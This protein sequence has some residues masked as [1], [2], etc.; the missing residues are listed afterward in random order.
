M[1]FNNL[2]KRYILYGAIV[3]VCIICIIL[4]VYHQIF[5]G[6]VHNE[7]ENKLSV[8]ENVVI[9]EPTENPKNVLAEF[10]NLFTNSFDKQGST[11]SNV[12]KLE[13]FEEED[14]IYTAYE[15][16]TDTENYSLDLKLPVVNI[17]GKV[18]GDLNQNTQNIFV[19]KANSIMKGTE[20]YTIYTVEYCGFINDN[21]LSLVIKA[22]LKEGTSAQ[23][24]MVQT[25]NYDMENN[26]VLKLN[27]VLGKYNLKIQDINKKIDKQ[28]K[29]AS[30]QAETIAKATG[31][32]VYTRVLNDSMYTTDNAN[33]F[34]IGKDGQIYIV[35]AYG[36]NNQ[37]SEMDVIKL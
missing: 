11:T 37:T 12:K 35:Y 32:I 36:N 30:E 33:N 3:L 34:F 7:S 29:E 9:E 16:K 19:D 13:G 5:S 28:V 21:I 25:Y 26:T 22:T 6:K 27:D 10:N 18:A 8:K 2:N 17:E 4:A 1:N 20:K 23:R 31:Q 15:Y 24:V 14:Y